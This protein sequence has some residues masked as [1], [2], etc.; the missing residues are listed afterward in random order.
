MI[1]TSRTSSLETWK[2]TQRFWSYVKHRKQDISGIAPLKKSDGLI[3][4]DAA[5]QA[6]ILNK[7]FNSVYTREDT[8]NIPSKDPSRHKSMAKITVST[9]GVKKFIWG[10]N[11]HKAI[12]PDQTPT[13]LLHDFADELGPTL[14]VIFHRELDTRTIPDDWIEAG[15]VPVFKNGDRHQAS[16]YRPV[17]P[18]SVTNRV[19]EN[20]IHSQIMDHFDRLKIVTDKQLAIIQAFGGFVIG[21]SQVSS[22]SSFVNTT[23]I[24]L[25]EC[26]LF[27][28]CRWWVFLGL[29]T[30]RFQCCSVFLIW[31]SARNACFHYFSPSSIMLFM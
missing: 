31:C 7:Q 11:V 24:D 12:G 20:V 2:T 15:I 5:T 14:S 13:R 29:L 4:S 6:D 17:S 25:V 23:G 26:P 22:F 8:G 9:N 10:L 1:S 16:N 21:L 3:Y 30:G 18:M 28:D 19:V 27:E